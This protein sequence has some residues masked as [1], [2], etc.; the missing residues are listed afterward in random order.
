MARSSLGLSRIARPS[1]AASP[2]KPRTGR[3]RVWTSV[4]AVALVSVVTLIPFLE[5][6]T[7]SAA[8]LSP[9]ISQSSVVDVAFDSAGNLYES[10]FNGNVNVWPTTSG[11]IFGKSV[12]AGQANTLVTLNNTPGIA[13]DSAGDLFIANENGPSGGSIYVLPASNTTIFGQSV[14]ANTLT[15]LTSLTGLDNPLGLAFDSAGN[16]YY[17]TQNGISVLPQA[18]GMLFGQTV[19]ADTPT[20]LVTGLTQGGFLAL[21]AAGDLFYTDVGDQM[22]G[23][24]T[25]NVLPQSN[26]IIFGQSVT[27]DTPAT[28]V[29]GLTDAAGLSIDTSGNV[30]VDYYGT[31]GV[32]SSSSSPIDG[33]TVTANTLSTLAVGLLG[34]LGS[35]YY[36]GHVY[37]ADQ[38]MDSVDQLTTPTASI[39]GVTFGGSATNPIII[40]K[41]TGFATSRPTFPIGC[42]GTGSDYKYGNLY[43]SDTTNAWDA[44]IP[45]DC[46]GLTV[47]KQKPTSVAFGLG[48]FYSTGFQLNSGDTFTVGVDGTTFTGTVSY[49]APSGA[50]VTKLSPKTGPGG[51][52]TAVTITGTGLSGTKY[53]F[54]GSSPA[55]H[56]VVDSA[57]EV[58]ADA[59][60]G[61]GTVAV[62]AVTGTGGVSTAGSKDTFTYLAPTI[63]S[64]SPTK[65]STAGGKTVT[66]TGTN[67]GG[68]TGVTFGSTAAS[69]FTVNS[70]T[71]ITAVTPAESA[72]TVPVT[73]TTPG[74]TSNS[75]NYKFKTP[76]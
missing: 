5:T 4:W 44:G 38:V 34:D 40:V 61:S 20:S 12:T 2:R 24:A 36:N 10:G 7:A 45:G 66:I 17:A 55:T 68:A 28:L 75:V 59:P 11:T 46:I 54:F 29:S 72:G 60:S 18:N 33:T 31:V 30:Y 64:I 22:S 48:S 67:L 51:G 63:T 19:T 3:I 56:V 14:T 15:Q 6:G 42:S 8:E 52:G 74:G 9:Q 32:L 27:A 26:G 43:L 57:T 69:S 37:I 47:S 41:G 65:G 70:E 58:T 13:F 76:A 49:A 16:L 62:T 53:V 23:T 73:V 21:D 50:T 1:S 25:V 39:T 35:T 71:Q